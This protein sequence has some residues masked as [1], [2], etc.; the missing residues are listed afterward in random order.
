[1]QVMM[2]KFLYRVPPS[3]MPLLVLSTLIKSFDLLHLFR[4]AA[5]WEGIK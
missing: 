1:M 3:G 5:L 2:I 4:N